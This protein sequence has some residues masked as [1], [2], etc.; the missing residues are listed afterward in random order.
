[1]AQSASQ[2]LGVEK[3]PESQAFL[4]A[5]CQQGESLLVLTR[6]LLGLLDD[7]GAAELA[8][9]LREAPDRST[10]RQ[11][12]GFHPRAPSPGSPAGRLP[13]GQFVS[14]PDLENLA[15]P[16]SPLEVYDELSDE[17]ET[18]CP[19]SR[20]TPATGLNPYGHGLDDLLAR[21][22][23]QRWSPRRLLEEVAR[24][25]VAEQARHSLDRRLQARLGRFKPLANFDWHWPSEIDRPLIERLSPWTSAPKLVTSCSLGPMAWARRCSSKIWLTPLC[26]PAY[27]VLFRTASGL[28]ADL[29]DDSPQRLR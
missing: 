20:S 13:S 10:P 8:A 12:R 28:L 3:F 1:M 19:L 5:A 11:L 18:G 4:H 26:W 29:H 21:A 27:P 7:Y 25:E 6:Q 15:V 16:T 23:A 24:S 14:P 2:R 9:A 17:P 22:T